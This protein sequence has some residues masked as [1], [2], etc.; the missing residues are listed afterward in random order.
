M[1]ADY[2]VEP[3][4]GYPAEVYPVGLLMDLRCVYGAA[5]IIVLGRRNHPDTDRAHGRRQ[6]ATNLR[7]TA[8]D[9]LKAIRARRRSHFNGYLAEF[10][11]GGPDLTRCGHGWTKARA[12]ASLSRAVE[13]AGR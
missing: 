13:E 3:T 5:R 8:R 12:V 10:T 2:R 11:Y 6:L 1:S 7:L 4:S 9:T